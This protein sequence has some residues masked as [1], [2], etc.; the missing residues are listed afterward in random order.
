MNPMILA[1][2]CYVKR[3]G[4][5]LM[6]HRNK[7]ANDIHAGKWNGLGK[8]PKN[9]SGMRYRK[10]RAARPKCAFPWTGN[11]LSFKGNN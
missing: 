5:T 4:C 9:V 10:S 6:V 3:D 2:L 7:K 8:R 1:T 11:I